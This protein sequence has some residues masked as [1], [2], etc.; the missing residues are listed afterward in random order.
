MKGQGWYRQ[1]KSDI[2]AVLRMVRLVHSHSQ[3]RRHMSMRIRTYQR[4]ALLVTTL[5]AGGSHETD[6]IP[7][8]LCRVRLPL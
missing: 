2:K 7:S 4:A 8:A 1:Q 6:R 3:R 5:A